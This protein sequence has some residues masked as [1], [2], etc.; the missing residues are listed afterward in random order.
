MADCTCPSCV[1][2]ERLYRMRSWAVVFF[3]IGWVGLLVVVFGR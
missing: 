2:T 3:V 1:Q